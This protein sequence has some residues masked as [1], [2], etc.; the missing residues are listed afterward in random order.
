M[1]RDMDLCRRILL[2]LEAN[3]R[4]TGHARV[5]LSIEGVDEATLSYHVM[6]LSEAGLI[7]A[8]DSSDLESQT[9]QP[10][11]LTYAGHE[12]LDAARKETFWQKAKDVALEKT[13]GMSLDLL[14]TILTKLATDA[15][16]GGIS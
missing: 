9:W 15:A 7:T 1:K 6:L 13:G 16:L 11:R 5:K 12:F 4:A 14:K 8:K 3:P 10:K 2:D